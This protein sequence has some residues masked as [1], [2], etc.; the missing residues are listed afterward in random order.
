MSKAEGRGDAK[1]LRPVCVCSR[2]L[3][4]PVCLG[5]MTGVGEALRRVWRGTRSQLVIQSPMDYR[6]DLGLL[7]SLYGQLRGRRK[8]DLALPCKES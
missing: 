4:K 3:K 5:T 6:R 7:L 8:E 2:I 1:A